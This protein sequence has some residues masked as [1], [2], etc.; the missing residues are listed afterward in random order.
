MI[1]FLKYFLEKCKS[2]ERYVLLII[3]NLI[4]KSYVY[5]RDVFKRDHM[6]F[7]KGKQLF[8]SNMFFG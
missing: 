6:I 5:K 2:K 8:F 3:F 7:Q 4:T 1:L